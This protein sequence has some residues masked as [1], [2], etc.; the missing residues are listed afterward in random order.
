MPST[1]TPSPV[2][3]DAVVIGAGFA[4]L[5]AIHKLRESNFTIKAIESGGDV[6]GTWYW[7]RY[8]GARCD[9]ES[10]SYSYTFDPKL[11]QN[12][13]WSERFA[14][15]PEIL[16][17][18]QWVADELDLRSSITF[19]TR[20]DK[21]EY[22]ETSSTW[23]VTTSDGLQTRAR[24]LISAVGCLSA[25]SI[26]QFPGLQTYAGEVYHTG[27]WP[28]HEVNFT[29]KR[30]A[31][32][33]TGSSGIQAIPEIAKQAANLT[34]FQ[35]TPNYSL[36][37]RN[38]PLYADEHADAVKNLDK[39]RDRARTCPTGIGIGFGLNQALALNEIDRRDTF[40][41][42]WHTGGNLFVTAF[43]DL[44]TDLAA[45]HEAA[46][47][48]REKIA[49]IV[50][51]P[52]TAQ[53][54][55]PVDYPIGAKRICVDTDY[56][57]TFNSPNV[58]LVDLREDP[59]K[60]ITDLGIKTEHNEFDVD[61]IV[62]ATGYDGMTGPLTRMDIRGRGGLALA[63]K[64]SNGPTNY[65]GVA[66]SEFPNMFTITGPGSPSVLANV[67]A[68]IEQ[69]VEW[70]AECMVYMRRNKLHEIE[71]SGKSEESWVEHVNAIA[72]QTLYVHAKSWYL[73]DNIEGKTRVFMPYP[74]GLNNYREKCAAIA[75][76]DYEGFSFEGDDKCARSTTVNTLISN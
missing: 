74:G 67:I 54:L 60:T 51:D 9:V 65:L 4:G 15:Q 22:D 61:V 39:R 33:G 45:N 28:H 50:E 24:F 55:T 17:Y 52:K 58:D 20:V 41:R 56:Y 47:Y 63:D 70:I 40:D 29:G 75:N 25:E 34:V 38:R 76:A 35:R 8:P 27:R 18:A 36:P 6:G 19:N 11:V 44:A 30:V 26:P 69:H 42:Y 46:E 14:S 72:E 71:A 48:V 21:A 43:S 3:C 37:A 57:S 16:A 68:S 7:N 32:I 12:W 2:D 31:V 13:R 62:F 64:W 73:G 59:L 66:L 49:T 10:V 23:V 1:P 53:T 5:Y